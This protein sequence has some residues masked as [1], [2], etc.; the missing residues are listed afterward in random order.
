[1]NRRTFFEQLAAVTLSRV[2]LDKNEGG[3]KHKG[4]LS[5]F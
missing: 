4:I 3:V 2:P 5:V 1:M